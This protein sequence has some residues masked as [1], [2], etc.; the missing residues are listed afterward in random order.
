MYAVR[1]GGLYIYERVVHMT[2][3]KV[4]AKKHEFVSIEG[5]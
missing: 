3:T 5:D 4:A 1:C 2:Y